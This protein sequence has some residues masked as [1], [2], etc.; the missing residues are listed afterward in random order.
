MF[1]ILIILIYNELYSYISLKCNSAK[2]CS[3]DL[4]WLPLLYLVQINLSW[5][6]VNIRPNYLLA[7][8]KQYIFF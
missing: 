1:K 6:P 5:L 2:L 3:L 4:S 7:L 8:I